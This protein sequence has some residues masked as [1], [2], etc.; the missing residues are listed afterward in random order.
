MF[1]TSFFLEKRYRKGSKMK[2]LVVYYSRSGNTKKVAE[3]VSNAFKCDIE[4]I[5]DTKKRTGLWGWL[6]SGRDAT[7]GAVTQIED[8]KRDLSSYDLIIIGTPIFSWNVSAAVRTFLLQYQDQIKS[9]AFFC[10]EGGGGGNRAFGSMEKVLG[11][12][13]VATLIVNEKEVKNGDYHKKASEFIDIIR[14]KN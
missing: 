5:V 3:A 4:A 6:T 11:K 12:K 1:I 13:P 2:T 9:A 7:I 10:T 14:S 8:F